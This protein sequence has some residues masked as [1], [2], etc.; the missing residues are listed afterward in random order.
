M[1]TIDLE[2][3]GMSCGSCVDHVTQALKPIKGVDDVAVDLQSG[4]VRVSGTFDA[5]AERLVSALAAAGYRALAPVPLRTLDHHV[6]SSPRH[7]W[8]FL[9]LASP[10]L[11]FVSLL[12]LGWNPIYPGIVAMGA[13]A[14]AVAT[15]LCRPDLWQISGATHSSVA[16]YFWPCMPR[17]YWD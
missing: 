15:V 9:A 3:Q 7:R 1:N 11:V 14:G 2:I 4:R 12:P 16:V 6:R 5:G 8:H 17:F 10:F 13:G